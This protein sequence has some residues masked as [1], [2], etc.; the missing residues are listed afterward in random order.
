MPGEP[1]KSANLERQGAEAA[2]QDAVRAER[3][4]FV[5]IQ[6]PLPILLSPVAAALLAASLWHAVD[7]RRL[8]VWV[9]GVAVL[10]LVRISLMR[11]YPSI[12][13]SAEHVKKWER[14]FVV[15]IA[16]VALWWGVGGLTLLVDSIAERTLVF[17]FL[18]M[19]GGGAASSYA[20]HPLTVRL[21]VLCLALPAIIVFAAQMELVHGVLAFGGVMYLVAT[22]KAVRTL[23][24]LFLRA[25][26]LTL[27]LQEARDRAERLARTDDLTGLNN[28]RAFYEQG[29][30][31]I[32]QARR[33]KQP[34]SLIMLDIDHFKAIN[35]ELG[36]AAGDDVLRKLADVLRSEQ[37][38]GDVLGRLGGEEFGIL[39]ADASK[40]E[41]SA[42]ADELRKCVES[43][44]LIHATSRIQLSISVGV[45]TLKAEQGLSELVA[46]ADRA[47]Y[48]AKRAGRN[49]VVVSASV[50]PPSRT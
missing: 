7:H 18:M 24:T 17:C 30:Q 49:R 36:H 15:S 37:R 4:R 39:I 20:A 28:R 22:L 26:R 23:D 33:Y 21:S 14:A 3:V 41:A 45:S 35:D 32:L 40:S 2:L 5:F 44:E 19:M 12:T 50:A 46:S 9:A 13:P 1:Q 8:I 16:L 48:A 42:I 6:S 34:L 47:L 38:E 43:C 27:D 31:A 11:T 25:H 10:S 29:E